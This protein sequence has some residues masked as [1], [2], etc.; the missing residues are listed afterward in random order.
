MS[1]FIYP[2]SPTT[3]NERLTQVSESYK[4]NV[5]FVLFSILVF[6]LGYL[7]VLLLSLLLV[8][9]GAIAAIGVLSLNISWI[10]L[11]LALGILMVVVMFFVY[12]VKFFFKFSSDEDPSHVE[13]F[14]KDHPKLFEFVA[15][16]CQ[17]TKAPFPKKIV[18]SPR[19]NAS[20]FYNSSFLSMFFPVRKN[21]EIGL[22]LVNSVNMSEFKAIIA[23]EFGHFSQ[24]STRIG[25]YVYR[26]HKMLHNLL[27]DNEGWE[28]T[29]QSFSSTHVI[30]SWFARLTIFMVNGVIKFLLLLY[31]F[32][33]KNYMALSREM[34]FHADSVAVSVSGNSN[35]I[36]ALY[37][38]DFSQ[39]AYDYTLRSIY[40]Y[41]T[42]DVRYPK[43][44]FSLMTRN[45]LYLARINELK[46]QNNLPII[47]TEISN[48]Y[49]LEDRVKYKDIWATHPPIT[50]REKN[51]NRILVNAQAVDSSP[52]ELFSNIEKLQE[53]L[54]LKLTEL[55]AK[56]RQTVSNDDIISYMEKIEKEADFS[57]L[58]SDF[59]SYATATAF[60]PQ[61]DN[62][63]ALNAV[64]T[65]QLNDVFNTAITHRVKRH[66]KN[67]YEMSVL[68][69][70]KLGEIETKYF[71]FD[72]VKYHR[73]D[74][75]IVMVKLQKDIDAET[76]WYESHKQTIAN[77]F[78]VKAKSVNPALASMYLQLMKFRV[79]NIE[80]Q[81]PC[82]ELMD[83]LVEFYHQELSKNITEDDLDWIRKKIGRFY[84]TYLSVVSSLI[85]EDIPVVLYEDNI[86]NTSF[87]DTVVTKVIANPLD[88]IHLEGYVP[89][90]NAIEEF[91]Q[92]WATLDQKVFYKTIKTQD[93]ILK[94]VSQ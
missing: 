3:I 80:L 32:I 43:N 45:M 21:L 61:V 27:Y 40:N 7:L 4:K 13:I 10:S 20:V 59:Y 69:A 75:P 5:L 23:H 78:Y 68:K 93:E 58:Y 81:K 30:I 22:G 83:K 76:V 42:K 37:R 39:G 16:V 53:Q 8:Y 67:I 85:E 65:W 86:L 34:E 36:T 60:V 9:Y 66:N 57:S 24:S 55:D 64:S 33:N 25:S 74:A 73:D 89:F 31:K 12:I 50:E 91:L 62:Q 71:E 47:N 88:S 15:K 38:T 84:D 44:F 48:T 28:S 14:E 41:N 19:V 70:I 87:K 35:I 72:N 18:L 46:L 11:I 77:W 6:I 79:K 94:S 52:W 2:E 82:L 92:H 51:A 63:E 26:F 54:S 90:T 49:F 1:N 56:T 29:L 17:E